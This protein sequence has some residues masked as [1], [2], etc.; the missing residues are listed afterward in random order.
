M[1]EYIIDNM[2]AS[3]Q[4]QKPLPTSAINLYHVYCNGLTDDARAM[5]NRWY[6]NDRKADPRGRGVL[7]SFEL[8]MKI[9]CFATCDMYRRPNE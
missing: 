8:A 6:R 9:F 2:L 4:A 7:S 5:V 3:Y 1:N